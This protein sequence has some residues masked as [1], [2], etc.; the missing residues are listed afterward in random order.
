M[1]QRIILE[2]LETLTHDEVKQAI[3]AAAKKKNKKLPKEALVHF[4]WG[5]PMDQIIATVDRIKEIQQ[6]DDEEENPHNAIVE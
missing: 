4:R 5:D 2:T 6:I 1:G 3:L